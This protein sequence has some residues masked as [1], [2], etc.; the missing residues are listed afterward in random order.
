MSEYIDKG[1]LY[2]K[3]FERLKNP[4]IKS[5]LSSIISELPT[6][7]PVHAAGAC[8][9]RECKHYHEFRT[10]RNKQLMRYCM[11]LARYDLEHR[12]KPDDFCSYGARIEE[13]K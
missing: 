12:A 4:T 7:D 6:I 13:E 1:S 11:R 2:T 9:C 3:I 8:Y 5:W 10:K